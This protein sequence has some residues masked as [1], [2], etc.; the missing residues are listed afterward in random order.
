[1]KVTIDEDRCAGHGICCTTCPGV[2]D[3][4]DDGH[5]TV[6]TGEVPAEHEEDVRRA[7]LNC[8]ERAITAE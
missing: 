7:V 8:P 3:L 1:M 4:S 2:F 5:A 6:G